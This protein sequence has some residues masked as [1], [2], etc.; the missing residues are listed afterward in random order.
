MVGVGLL[1]HS[2]ADHPT[3]NTAPLQ[4]LIIISTYAHYAWESHCIK[5]HD[6]KHHQLIYVVV[7]VFKSNKLHYRISFKVIQHLQFGACCQHSHCPI[8]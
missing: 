7:L 3:Q 8:K 6:H 1:D 2:R 4:I 5:L